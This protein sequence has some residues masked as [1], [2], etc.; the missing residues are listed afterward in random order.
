MGLWDKIKGEFIDIIEWTDDTNDT[1]VYRFERYGNEI[2]MGAQLTVREGQM[3]VFINEGQLADVF[4]PGRYEL[5]TQNMPIL[6]TLKGWKYGFN[7]PFKAEVY[8]CNTRQFTDLKWGTPGP[9]TMRDKDFGVVRVTA[10]GLYSL[11]ISDPEIFIK[12]IVGTDGRFTTDEINE[13][14]RGKVAVSIKE[15][16]PE[17][18]IPVIDLEG[19]VVLLGERLVEKLLPRFEQYGLEITEVQVQD[20][21]LPEEVEKAIDAGGAMR[22]IGNMQAYTQYKTAEAIDDAAKNPGG[23]ASGGM[24][25]GMGFAMANQMSN[26]MGN[27]NQQQGQTNF[28]MSGGQQQQQQPKG[29]AGPPPLPSEKTFFIAVN[30]QQVGP[31]TVSQ[32]KEEAKKGNLNGE[33]LV[34]TEGM[35]GWEKASQVADMAPV[36]SST[37]PPIPE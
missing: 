15:A 11:R 23:M 19:Q 34:W 28:G 30:K 14:L 36:F 9:V 1:L 26:A 7:S 31:L 22:A 33:T 6:T 29:P 13:N 17:A 2:K 21:G 10:Y 35:A 37:P 24:G 3:A 5:S 8:F 12:E 27:P 20:I 32:L 18:G 25:M 4:E 16:I